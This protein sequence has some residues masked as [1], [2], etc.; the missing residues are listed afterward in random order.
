[1]TALT[2]GDLGLPELVGAG[3]RSR[4][5]AGAMVRVRRFISLLSAA[6]DKRSLLMRTFH[7]AHY[8]GPHQESRER[9]ILLQDRKQGLR[10]GLSLTERDPVQTTPR[11]SGCGESHRT[12]PPATVVLPGPRP[13]ATKQDADCESYASPDER[14][15]PGYEAMP[16][17]HLLGW[18]PPGRNSR[19]PHPMRSAEAA[20]EHSYGVCCRQRCTAPARSA[21][22]Y[23]IVGSDRM[24]LA[25]PHRFCHVFP[26]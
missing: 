22:D 6:S 15:P 7:D 8:V 21:C 12:L 13:S 10:I 23:D 17:K 24:W 4:S 9:D 18:L 1:M 14:V 2:R 16:I 5:D 19:S 25:S 3:R 11:S 26:A 20:F